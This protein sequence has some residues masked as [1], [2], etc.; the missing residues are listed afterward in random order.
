MGIVELGCEI[1][2]KIVEGFIH[3]QVDANHILQRTG[4]KKVLLF[5]AQ[6]LALELFIIGVQYFSDGFGAYLIFHCA[7][8]VTGIEI[9][10]IKGNRSFSTPQTQQVDI[11]D[12][13]AGNRSVVR[14]TCDYAARNPACS[15][16]PLLIVVYFA[17]AAESNITGQIRL[18]DFPGISRMQPAVAE[19][20]LPAID[21]FLVKHAV[22]VTNTITNGRNLQ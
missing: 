21:D 15:P 1:I 3:V 8:I 4:N 18:F 22:L 14:N 19:F 17:V 10:K 2:I 11:I 7:V 16:V 20:F 5:Q 6:L 9:F 13:V 12:L